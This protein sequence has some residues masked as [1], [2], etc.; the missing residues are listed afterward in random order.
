MW[1][2]LAVDDGGYVYLAGASGPTAEQMDFLTVKYDP[3]GAEL[4]TASYDGPG[5][6]SDLAVAV[7]L[8]DDGNVYVCGIATVLAGSEF[9]YATIKYNPDGN[10]E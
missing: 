1:L 10:E 7:D 9:V 2:S 4:W 8:D 3:D 6:D 5:N